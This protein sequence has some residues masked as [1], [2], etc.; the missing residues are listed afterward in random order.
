MNQSSIDQAVAL[1]GLAQSIRVVQNLAWKGQ[2]NDTDFK[3][4][5]ASIRVI[6]SKSAVSIYGGSFELSTGLRILKLQLDVGSQ[7]KDPEFIN[8]AIN[9]ITLQKQV[10][11]NEQT[12]FMLLHGIEEISLNY[13]DGQIYEDDASFDSFVNDCSALYSRSISKLPNRIQVK[14]EPKF[15][16]KAKNQRIVRAALLCAIR[17]IF[18]WR[19]SGGSRWQFLFKKKQILETV[20]YLIN[21]PMK[22]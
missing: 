9:L 17:S 18:L 20:N 12:M 14:G 11:A 7:Q 4:V 8:L 3:A 13:L 22:E 21:N 19:Q 6:D 16:E 1:A 10:D 15:L 2:T 5:L